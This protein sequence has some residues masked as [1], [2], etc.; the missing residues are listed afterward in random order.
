MGV[1]I[2]VLLQCL[3]VY[4]VIVM[5]TGN[6]SWVG[7]GA[8]LIGM[9]AIPGTAI[10]NVIYMLSNKDKSASTLV[11]HCFLIAIIAPFLTL[12]LLLVG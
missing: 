5:N 7:L 11:L 8:F 3:F 4:I 2:P 6:G 9:F 12:L 10:F 1:V